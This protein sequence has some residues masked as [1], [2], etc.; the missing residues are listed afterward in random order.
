MT[1]LIWYCYP[2]GTLDN[3]K[4]YTGRVIFLFSAS[5][6][7]ATDAEISSKAQHRGKVLFVTDSDGY[8]YIKYDEDGKESW[9][10][11]TK[12]TV[13][14]GDIIEFPDT[15]PLI[16][17]ASKSLNKTFASLMFVPGIKIVSS[18]IPKPEPSEKEIR[19]FADSLNLSNAANVM[20]YINEG[21]AKYPT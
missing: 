1:V 20:D 16:N 5:L 7:M 9:L 11:V 4:N 13:N 8:T 14:V 10:S 17:F 19:E 15:P 2:G 18:F 21:I 3:Y 12:V 6:S